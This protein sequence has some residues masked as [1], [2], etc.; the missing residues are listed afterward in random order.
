M[1]GLS[2]G[3]QEGVEMVGGYFPDPFFDPHRQSFL[4]SS[5]R[6]AGFQ[7]DVGQI[8]AGSPESAGGFDI[9]NVFEQIGQEYG[10]F[11]HALTSH[12]KL[13][14]SGD[15]KKPF[16]NNGAKGCLGR[17][18]SFRNLIF[19]RRARKMLQKGG[20]KKPIIFF[21]FYRMGG[22][23]QTYLPIANSF[24]SASASDRGLSDYWI[25]ALP[26]F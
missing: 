16:S 1:Q 5:H 26:A 17:A 4:E 3:D 14:V 11:G 23:N 20:A 22:A 9:F 12:G 19:S 18:W 6:F 13:A 25:K 8:V 21:N 7:A 2:P 24:L 15:I 10:Y